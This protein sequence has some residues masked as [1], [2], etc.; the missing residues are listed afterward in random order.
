[1]KTYWDLIPYGDIF[2]IEGCELTQ[3][4]L[5]VLTIFPMNGFSLKPLFMS[6]LQNQSSKGSMTT[7]VQIAKHPIL[8]E[9]GVPSY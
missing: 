5:T 6:N 9:A 1:M 2:T 7:S 3:T 8:F 4:V